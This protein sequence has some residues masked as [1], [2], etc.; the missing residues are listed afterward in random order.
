[1]KF[2]LKVVKEGWL[3]SCHCFSRGPPFKYI[4][5]IKRNKISM[6]NLSTTAIN[7]SKELCTI[8][9]IK[10]QIVKVGC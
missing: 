5:Q 2:S 10:K 6:K 9:N 1:M 3:F 4:I 7:G 8:M